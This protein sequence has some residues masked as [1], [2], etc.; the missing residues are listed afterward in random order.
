MILRPRFNTSYLDC[1]ACLQ[2][3]VAKSGQWSTLTACFVSLPS[4]SHEG[5]QRSRHAV[6]RHIA[7]RRWEGPKDNCV[8]HA[9]E[10]QEDNRDKG[11]CSSP[12]IITLSVFTHWGVG[13]VSQASACCHLSRTV[14]QV[15][16]TRHE[17]CTLQKMVCDL[18]V[19]FG[20]SRRVVKVCSDVSE[21]RVASV[22]RVTICFEWMLK[23][24]LVPCTMLMLTSHKPY[25]SLPLPVQSYECSEFPQTFVQGQYTLFS[26]LFHH[27]SQPHS[28]TLKMQAVR[29]LETNFHHAVY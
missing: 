21:E 20:G 1:W 3:S 26:P 22:L 29:P 13:Q 11:W 2:W 18:L 4:G 10:L 8:G 23:W 7:V 17:L 25:P 9:A 28:V 24:L 16:H 27:Q 14:H 6:R 5:Y 12:F 15:W 19:F